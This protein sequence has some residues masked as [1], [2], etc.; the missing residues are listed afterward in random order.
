MGPA[1]TTRCFFCATRGMPGGTCT[2]CR[3]QLPLVDEARREMKCPRCAVPLAT[4]GLAHDGALAHGC[5]RCRGVFVPPRAWNAIVDDPGLTRIVEARLPKV[6]AQTGAAVVPLLACPSCKKQMERARFS[7]TSEVV[8]DV[9][10]MHGMWLDGDELA[11]TIAYAERRA[12]MSDVAAQAESEQKWA[13]ATGRDPA[14]VAVE[15]ER[16]RIKA[17]SAQRMW[18]AKRA[19]MIAAGLF[20]ALRLGYYAWRLHERKAEAATDPTGEVQSVIER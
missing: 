12:K 15:L 3:S 17:E 18:K 1:R 16:A 11:A 20:L 10:I 6:A 14:V 8:I 7:A 4:I 5:A 13:Q 2:T 9:C 19:A